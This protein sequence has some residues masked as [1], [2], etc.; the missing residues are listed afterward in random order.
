MKQETSP[1]NDPLHAYRAKQEPEAPFA[2]SLFGVFK[3]RLIRRE[4][5]I[6]DIIAT[7]ETL[8]EQA[9]KEFIRVWNQKHNR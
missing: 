8:I 9:E 6:R 7:W 3:K 1:H 4:I 2:L 5:T